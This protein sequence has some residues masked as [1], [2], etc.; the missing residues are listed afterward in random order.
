MISLVQ[1]KT[2]NREQQ[3]SAYLLFLY[4]HFYRQHMNKRVLQLQFGGFGGGFHAVFM[5]SQ[6]IWMLAVTLN[7]I[8]SVLQKHRQKCLQGVQPHRFIKQF[9]KRHLNRYACTLYVTQ[10]ARYNVSLKVYYAT[11]LQAYEHMTRQLLIQG[12]SSLQ[13]LTGLLNLL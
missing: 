6:D 2:R 8:M 13:D 5:L 4:F 10:L 7:Q 3:L 9:V 12:N 1:H 11:F